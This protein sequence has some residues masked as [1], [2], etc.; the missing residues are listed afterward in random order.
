MTLTCLFSFQKCFLSH[1]SGFYLRFLNSCHPSQSSEVVF[2]LPKSLNVCLLFCVQP[3]SKINRD[4]LPQSPNSDSIGSWAE[5][6]TDLRNPSTNPE[7]EE[8]LLFGF[9]SEHFRQPGL[10]SS[11]SFLKCRIPNPT[12][13]IVSHNIHLSTPMVFGYIL[14]RSQ[15][16]SLAAIL[17]A[18]FLFPKYLP[19]LTKMKHI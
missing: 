14:F 2:M 12:S 11:G 15:G 3:K 17:P 7:E 8:R 9:Q 4:T 18:I 13:D 6:S 1:H 16:Q 19:A 10:T 5:S